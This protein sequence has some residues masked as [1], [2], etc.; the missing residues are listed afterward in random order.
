MPLLLD[1]GFHLKSS[2]EEHNVRCLL[3]SEAQEEELHRL[4]IGVINLMPCAEQYEFNLLLPLGRTQLHIDTVWIRLNHHKYQS[5]DQRHLAEQYLTF[6]DAIRRKPLDGLI[7]TGAAVDEIPFEAVRYWGELRQI[8]EF[9]RK[10]IVSTIGLCWGAMA[11]AYLIGIDKIGFQRKLF[12]VFEIRNL[13]H[14]HTLMSET[15]DVFWCPQAR[16]AGHADETLE[17]ARDRGEINLLAH[18]Q[19]AGYVI[20]E[21]KDRR[22]LMHLGHPEYNSRR[23]VEEWQRDQ[24]LR[25]TNADSPNNFDVARPINRWRG[26]RAAFFTGWTSYLF[27]T[28]RYIDSRPEAQKPPCNGPIPNDEQV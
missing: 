22:F 9:A 6:D 14:T 18:S 7:L 20:F 10:H 23:L 11:L 21:T 19:E 17:L 15:D 1:N 24:A 25:R 27:E 4:R 3:P 13:G 26:H 28:T 8:L 5:S 12:G 2:L 16:Y